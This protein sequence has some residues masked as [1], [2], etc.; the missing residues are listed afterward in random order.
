M[1]TLEQSYRVNEKGLMQT[2]PDGNMHV[3]LEVRKDRLV[4]YASY[5]EDG[6]GEGSPVEYCFE[7]F[8]SQVLANLGSVDDDDIVTINKNDTNRL[9]VSKFLESAHDIFNGCRATDRMSEEEE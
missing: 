5:G 9:F 3:V 1:L 2:D 8:V 7:N 6:Y 4:V